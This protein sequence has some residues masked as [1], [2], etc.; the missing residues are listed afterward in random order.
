VKEKINKK[1]K[2][3]MVLSPSMTL[4]GKN[5]LNVFER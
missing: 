2:Q 4:G 1:C 3:K 5:G